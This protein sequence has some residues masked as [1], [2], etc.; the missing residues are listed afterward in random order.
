MQARSAKLGIAVL[1][2]ATAA[3]AKHLRDASL[4]KPLG[5][6]DFHLCQL[7]VSV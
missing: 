3:V 2:P 5:V 7:F 4:T 6:T 1:P